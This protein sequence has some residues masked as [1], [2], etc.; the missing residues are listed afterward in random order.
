MNPTQSIEV[1]D[2]PR[3][4]CAV[5]VSWLA[6]GP[7]PSLIDGNVISE[8]GEPKVHKHP[9]IAQ[10]LLC[11]S[12]RK[13]RKKG[14]LPMHLFGKT[15][16]G[17]AY[18]A[19]LPIEVSLPPVGTHMI[20]NP[21]VT[22]QQR[23]LIDM[24]N[25]TS[26]DFYWVIHVPAPMGTG[27]FLEVYAP[28]IDATTKTRG[29]RFKPAGAQ[30]VSF[31]LPWSN[32]L[33]VVPVD[34]GRAA[35]SG[36]AIALR[37]IEDNTTETMNTPM[38]AVL[39]VC[40]ANVR[41]SGLKVADDETTSVEAFN[42]I[43]VPPPVPL[44]L[45]LQWNADNES[46]VEVN[47]EGVA[48]LPAQIAPE[49]TPAAVLTP[50]AEKPSGKPTPPKL[51]KKPRAT[52][53][54]SGL[55]NTRWFEAEAVTAGLVNIMQW[56]NLTINPNQRTE[57]GE[58]ISRAYKRNIWVTG[59]NKAGFVKT[60]RTK[61]AI[62]R[63]PQASGLMEF[64]DSRTNS[65]RYLVE[66]GGNIEFTIIP[67]H[68]SNPI[69]EVRP[70]YYNNAWLR[71]DE[72]MNQWRYRTLVYN[73]NSEIGDTQIRIMVKSGDIIFDIPTKPRAQNSALTFLANEFERYTKFLDALDRHEP[74]ELQ[75]NADDDDFS[76]EDYVA[77]AAGYGEQEGEMD[78][79]SSF[80]EDLDQDEFAVE[81]WNGVLTPGV[82][83]VVPLNLATIQDVSGG[84]GDSTIAEKFTRNAHIC[85]TEA[86]TMGPLVGKYVIELRLPTTVTGNIAHVSLPG[87]MTDEAALFAFGLSDILSIA[88]AGLQAVGGPTVSAG[89]SAARAIW[90]AVKG[91]GGKNTDKS[92]AESAN[93]PQLA[94][95]L[96]I[97]RF[98]NFL[99]PIAQNEMADP[100]MPNIMMLARDFID[101][102]GDAFTKDIP[103]R[104]WGLMQNV[105]LERGLFNRSVIPSTTME[106][107]III[108][109]DRWS[110]IAEAF[111]QHSG[112]FEAGSKQY[113][114][115]IKF[116]SVAVK[117][118]REER[119]F[120][121]LKSVL[122]YQYTQQDED[123]VAQTIREQRLI[124]QPQG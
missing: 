86:G 92:N 11:Y 107:E 101:A 118:I 112:T 31:N 52:K 46:S 78:P 124:I 37:T 58:N 114:N 27:V 18:S 22:P 63:P 98:I 77:P 28:E 95:D 8:V 109:H 47:S 14:A 57:T 110:Y 69:V 81:M 34:S 6:K 12:L 100:T 36:G 44:P 45:Q 122:D 26:A 54:Q 60:T 85:P 9:A 113:E 65:N 53:N 40:V 103:A 97:S 117:C 20:I 66:L 79:G 41:C 121:T 64:S 70:R 48:N 16:I 23:T 35:Q 84:G 42:F 29:V 73:R 99:K 17:N 68:F 80:D 25:Y 24:Y 43:P 7:D 116:T 49:A 115:F 10:D 82:E 89:I 3:R 50:E 93:Q 123:F 21:R 4:L 76:T 13:P 5:P 87:D 83:R 61:V 91:I 39:F 74:V 67:L 51:G 30:T 59:S 2:M 55:A 75:W 106:N 105:S 71:T 94:G 96:N 108:P 1:F 88:T 90:N 32:D 120:M 62:S 38:K 56:F 104:I 119:T 72:A 19:F 111:G 33:K 15:W 102:Q